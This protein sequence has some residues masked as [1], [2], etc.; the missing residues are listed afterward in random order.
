MGPAGDKFLCNRDV[1][2]GGRVRKE[3]SDWS[4]PDTLCRALALTVTIDL[5]KKC[6]RGLSLNY[7]LPFGIIVIFA[8]SRVGRGIGR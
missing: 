6:R 1:G 4:S 8:Y 3:R 7:L 5:Y 2:Y